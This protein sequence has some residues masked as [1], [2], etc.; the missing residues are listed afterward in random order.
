MILFDFKVPHVIL[1]SHCLASPAYFSAY[2]G[3]L[4]C[5]SLLSTWCHGSGGHGSFS[6]L[7]TS[8][9]LQNSLHRHCSS[10]GLRLSPIAY[11]PWHQILHHFHFCTLLLRFTALFRALNTRSISFISRTLFGY[12]VPKGS[13]KF[14]NT[15]SNWLQ[16]TWGTKDHPCFP[17]STG[18]GNGL[19]NSATAC[20]HFLKLFRRTSGQS[21]EQSSCASAKEKVKCVGQTMSFTSLTASKSRVVPNDSRRVV[22]KA[23]HWKPERS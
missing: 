16:R 14:A 4:V 1:P 3:D 8:M 15:I 13:D 23:P 22:S 21:K 2:V 11:W 9:M 19:I 6:S 12:V 18:M 17:T 10:L 5:T 7:V 20:I